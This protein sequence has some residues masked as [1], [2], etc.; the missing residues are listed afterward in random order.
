M[1]NEKW[2]KVIEYTSISI[3]LLISIIS[4]SYF[5]KSKYTSGIADRLKQIT[6]SIESIQEEQSRINESVSS[7]RSISSRFEIIESEFNDSIRKLREIN[8]GLN[9]I[10]DG[11]RSTNSNIRDIQSEYESGTEELDTIIR[12]IS[13]RINELREYLEEESTD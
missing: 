4:S 13:E 3:I 11:F 9:N 7:I 12:N 10:E 6:R 1:L 5:L 2:K 8:T